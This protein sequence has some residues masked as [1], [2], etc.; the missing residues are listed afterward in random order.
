M[1]LQCIKIHSHTRHFDVHFRFDNSLKNMVRNLFKV[2]SGIEI[3]FLNLC[4]LQYKSSHK[5][6]LDFPQSK[7][8][9][10]CKK[11]CILDA[12]REN[13]EKE[14]SPSKNKMQYVIYL[15]AKLHTSGQLAQEN[16]NPDYMTGV[17]SCGN[18]HQG[19]IY[20]FCSQRQA[21]H[22]LQIKKGHLRSHSKSEKSI[23]RSGLI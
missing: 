7:L 12:I 2:I 5:P 19:M 9:H 6:P 13:R 1:F 4:F 14:P 18:L 23:M 15:R 3:S 21:L 10:S 20:T 11:C 8:L 17:I 22:Y 16:A